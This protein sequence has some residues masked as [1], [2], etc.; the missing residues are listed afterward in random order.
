MGEIPDGCSLDRINNEENYSKENC[1]WADK[2]TQSENRRPL[3][4]RD[5]FP[6]GVFKTTS[7]KNPFSATIKIEGKDYY[8]GSFSSIELAHKAYID[9]C[10]EWHGKIPKYVKILEKARKLTEEVK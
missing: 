7:R 3:T 8:L 5:D 9:V 6:T 4:R 2:K 10:L 1:R